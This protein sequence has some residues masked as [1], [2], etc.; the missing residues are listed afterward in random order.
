MSD[1]TYKFVKKNTRRNIRVAALRSRFYVA[2][3]TVYAAPPVG[4]L[5][6]VFARSV[7]LRAHSH[8]KTPAHF[9]AARLLSQTL[10]S[11]AKT[12]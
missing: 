5:A 6:Y 4:G 3:H 7:A 2:Y 1:K 12:S 9:C 11:G 8:A 10:I